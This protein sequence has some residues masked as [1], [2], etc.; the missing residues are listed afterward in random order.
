M[1]SSGL[2]KNW[3]SCCESLSTNGKAPI[4]L[5]AP[6]FALRYSKGE[7]RAFQQP[8]SLTRQKLNAVIFLA[9]LLAVL[10]QALSAHAAFSPSKIVIAHA[11]MNARTVVLWTA[12]EQKFFAKYG[13]DAQV[14]FIRQAPILLAGQ[15]NQDTFEN[16]RSGS[17]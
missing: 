16:C 12:D 10:C 5:T 2:L 15:Y 1:Q 3:I 7:R 11:G 8:A 14:I 6:P 9:P 4:I 17:G 13:S